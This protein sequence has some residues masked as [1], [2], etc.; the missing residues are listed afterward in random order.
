MRAE[1]L[2]D[3]TPD[4]L[5]AEANACF[6][7]ANDENTNLSGGHERRLL[8]HLQAQFYLTTAARKRADEVADRD[9]K[10][11]EEIAERDFKL[12]RWVM[13]LIGAEIV[14]SIIFGVGGIVEGWKQGQALDGQVGVLKHMDATTVTTAEA[15]EAARDSLKS[16]ADAQAASLKILQEEQA[17]REK[18]PQLVLYLGKVPIDGASV[19]P[20][21]SGTERAFV[22]ISLVLTNTGTAPLTAFRL[23]ALAPPEVWINWRGGEDGPTHDLSFLPA[24][25]S[26]HVSMQIGVPVGHPTFK[27]AFTVDAMELRAGRNTLGYLTVLPPSP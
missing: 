6:V 18:K 24:K 25:Q 26:T 19:Q 23:H 21:S 12:E 16:L 2:E 4:Q 15:M 5:V 7:K 27:V 17:E 14:L 1:Q 13:W 9:R 11:N 20:K 22:N 8:Y 3:L 10:R